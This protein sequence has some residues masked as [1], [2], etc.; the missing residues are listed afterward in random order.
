MKRRISSRSTRNTVRPYG[1]E[2]SRLCKCASMKKTPSIV[3][4]VEESLFKMSANRDATYA[5]VYTTQSLGTKMLFSRKSGRKISVSNFHYILY[6]SSHSNPKYKS[7]G[8]SF[9]NF[10]KFY[11]KT[12]KS[13]IQWWAYKVTVDT[14]C[15]KA[16]WLA[17][18]MILFL[19]QK[20]TWTLDI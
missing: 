14:C 2:S 20:R 16:Q 11:L 1:T 9:Q 8:K 18:H 13:F 17:Q 7:I 12:L 4:T 6:L 15:I 5:G 19:F 3:E 10:Q